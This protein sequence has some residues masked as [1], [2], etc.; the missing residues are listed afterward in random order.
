MITVI[1]GDDIEKTRNLFIEKKKEFMNSEAFL[2]N[3]KSQYNDLM[4]YIS[5]ISFFEQK[6]IV[7]IENL[8]NNQSEVNKAKILELILNTKKDNDYIIWESKSFTDQKIKSIYKDSI[9]IK[10]DLPKQIFKFMDALNNTHKKHIMTIFDEVVKNVEP[11]IIFSM[12]VRQFR[13]MIIAKDNPTSLKSELAPWQISK[14]N[15]QVQSTDI[16]ELKNQYRQLLAID[17]NLKTGRTPYN[18][19]QLLDIFFLAN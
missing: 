3:E 19:K 9:Y 7:F 16:I 4:N 11:E 10:I 1:Y 18:Q 17:I 13:L 2:M 14:L 12:L 6:K 8:S 15:K 5:T